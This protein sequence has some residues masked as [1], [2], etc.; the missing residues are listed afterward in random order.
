[1]R[2]VLVLGAGLVSKPLV[3]Y[4]LNKGFKVLVASRTLSKAEKLV[5]DHPNGEAKRWVVEEKEELKNMVKDSDIVVSLLPYTYHVD[6]ADVCLEYRKPMVTTSYVSDKMKAL[7]QRAKDAGVILL[8]EIGLDPGIDHMSAMETIHRVEK[9]GGKVVSFRSLCGALPAPE[10][11]DNPFRYKFSWSPRGVALAA[12]NSARYLKEGKVVEVESKDLFRDV[13]TT[14]VEGIGM[15][16]VYPNRDSMPYIELYGIKDA[17]TM[18]RGTLR[19]PGWCELWYVISN[20][21]LLDVEEKE[22][23]SIT[24][25]EFMKKILGTEKEP[26]EALA[27]K[28]GVSVDSEP[29]KKLEWLG[30]FSDEPIK[31]T[32]GGAIDVFVDLLLEKL[33]YREGERDMVIL[34]DEVIADYGNRKVKYTSTLIDYGEIGKDTSIARTV[35]L[36]A[37]CAVKLILEGEIKETGVHIPTHPDIYE[38]VLKELAELGIKSEEKVEE[39]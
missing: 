8:N 35:S 34:K 29:I 6:V 25:R 20:S 9:E 23:G 1:M 4:L 13:F 18:F 21:G 28:T 26:E 37:A 36:P 12:R 31:T 19:Y 22:W 33:S 24:Y 15:L 38:P 17:E 32:K 14:E 2:K 5:G 27:E 39:V 7:D 11:S 30:I 16:E 3:D 10:A